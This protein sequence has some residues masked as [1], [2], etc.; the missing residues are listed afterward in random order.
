MAP[1]GYGQGS[2][3][4]RRQQYKGWGRG[5]PPISLWWLLVLLLVGAALL[6]WT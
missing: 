4:S 2:R 6:M 5:K 1:P 3:Y